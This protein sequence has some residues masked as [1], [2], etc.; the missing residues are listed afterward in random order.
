MKQS[1][2]KVYGK[3]IRYHG[4][5][6]GVKR[7]IDQ[8]TQLDLYD[9]WHSVNFSEIME[10]DEFYSTINPK[11]RASIMHYQP[12]YTAAVKAPIKFLANNY[13]VIG[14]SSACFLDLGCGRGKS[15]HVARSCLKHFNL[16]GIDINPILIKDAAQNLG[17]G[18][19]SY[20]KAK[21]VLI[22]GNVN[23]VDYGELLSPYDVIVVFNKNSFDK[24]TTENTKKLIGD[25]SIGKTLF[26]IYNNPVFENI[27][28]KDTCVFE[29]RGW[30]KNWN[31]KVFLI[32]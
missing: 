26:Y 32:P 11:D 14:A 1:R 25:A 19:G 7:V 9:I 5:F 30:H 4:L 16:L 20:L 12:T 23:D 6:R 31:T 22:A 2:V 27:F 18:E 24:R 15:L 8:I 29:M 17:V 13:Q 3:I 21:Q 10:G 28:A